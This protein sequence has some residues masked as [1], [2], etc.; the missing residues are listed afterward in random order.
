MKK[1]QDPCKQRERNWPIVRVS[2]YSLVFWIQLITLIEDNYA[3]DIK[4]GDVAKYDGKSDLQLLLEKLE[5]FFSL[6]AKSFPKSQYERKI[7]YVSTR[8]VGGPGQWWIANK[9]QIDWSGE[10]GTMWGSY[11]EFLPEHKLSFD[12]PNRLKEARDSL[13]TLIQGDEKT[14][15]FLA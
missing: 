4:I 7:Q 12:N 10:A 2:N 6:K 1:F 15:A 8:L 13:D 3:I 11:E 5:T 14:A 9:G